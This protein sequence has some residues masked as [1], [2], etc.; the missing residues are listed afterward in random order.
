MM[1]LIFNC[2]DLMHFKK[3]SKDT[4]PV[5]DY[6]IVYG[7]QLLAALENSLK[8]EYSIEEVRRLKYKF[9]YPLYVD[10]KA[11]VIAE[12]KG[13]MNFTVWVADKCIGEGEIFE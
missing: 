1:D 5:H 7:M 8:Q 12:K 13:K 10:Q 4:N 2:K 9:K 11:R 6:G 3:V